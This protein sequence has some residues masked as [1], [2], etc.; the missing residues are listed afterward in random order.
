MKKPSLRFRKGG[1]EEM[2]LTK[3]LH[4]PHQT[5]ILLSTPV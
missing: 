5:T 4:S 1:V 2:C 3:A